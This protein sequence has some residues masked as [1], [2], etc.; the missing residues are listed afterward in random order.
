M[1]S[2]NVQRYPSLCAVFYFSLFLSLTDVE[3][4][5]KLYYKE[6]PLLMQ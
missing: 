4:L 6:S 2:A 3:F 1:Q 5:A